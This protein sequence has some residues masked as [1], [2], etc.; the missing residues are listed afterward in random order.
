[1]R[2]DVTSQQYSNN[3]FNAYKMLSIITWFERAPRI[4]SATVSRCPAFR[5]SI[6]ISQ[7][8]VLGNNLLPASIPNQIDVST[9][10]HTY[11]IEMVHVLADKTRP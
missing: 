4:R 7:R 11:Y 3:D 6:M 9:N 1:M 5:S 8:Y 2:K 10:V